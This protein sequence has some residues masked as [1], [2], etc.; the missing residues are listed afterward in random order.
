MKVLHQGLEV[1]DY[2]HKGDTEEHYF[3]LTTGL[4]ATENCP[5]KELGVYKKSNIPGYCTTHAPTPEPEPEPDPDN[6]SSADVPNTPDTPD[7]PDTPDSPDTPGG[8][9]VE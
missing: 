5:K 6:S 8:D 7:A 4:L 9:P 2:E 1:K 3:C